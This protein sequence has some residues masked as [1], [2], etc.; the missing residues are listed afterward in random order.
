[1]SHGAGL[2]QDAHLL[3]SPGCA[4]AFITS[5]CDLGAHAGV[6][7]WSAQSAS[8]G[9]ST[10]NSLLLLVIAAPRWSKNATANACCLNCHLL[11]CV[12]QGGW[13]WN[14]RWGLFHQRWF[15]FWFWTSQHQQ[16]PV[17]FS[18]KAELPLWRKLLHGTHGMLVQIG[19]SFLLWTFPDP[20]EFQLFSLL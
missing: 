2:F 1:M 7:H 20:N 4:A 5:S 6:Q 8:I 9:F 16:F 18:N 11:Y 13:F 12:S 14:W 17:K 19:F 10:T 15:S 3:N